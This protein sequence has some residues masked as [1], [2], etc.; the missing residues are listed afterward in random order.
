MRIYELIFIIKPDIPDEEVDAAVEQCQ[1]WITD[2]GGVI[3]KI[4]RWGKKNLA[5]EIRKYTQGYYVLIQY[6]LDENPAHSKEIER[7]LRV[8]DAVIKFMT[9]RIDE[10]LKRAEKL[11]AK[12]AARNARK[13][14]TSSPDRPPHRAPDR[15]APAAP[16]QPDDQGDN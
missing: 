2:G 13:P 1:G 12:R 5:Y 3:D 4:D 16:A 8:A 6:R 14:Q 9:V 15:P 11:K 7:R 10:D